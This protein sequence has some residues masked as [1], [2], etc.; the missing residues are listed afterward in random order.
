[1]KVTLIALLLAVTATLNSASATLIGDRVHYILGNHNGW[2]YGQ[3]SATVETDRH[4]FALTGSGGFKI[5]INEDLIRLWW[6][7][8]AGLLGFGLDF[9]RI[10]DLDWNDSGSIYLEAIDVTSYGVSR[11]DPD[12][13][14][15]DPH[16]ITIPLRN[17]FWSSR[18]SRIS[19]AMETI[20][21][22]VY[23]VPAP[24]AALLMAIGLI[25]LI[26][27]ARAVELI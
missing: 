22:T 27:T 13:V 21:T 2:I 8:N 15:F 23:P 14:W 4:E 16:E 26:R 7:P 24:S 10:Y 20:D 18:G 9:L 12:T 3:G 5:D 6:E 1:M 11:F 25:G 19:I 17:T